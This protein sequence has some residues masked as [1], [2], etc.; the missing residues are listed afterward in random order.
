MKLMKTKLT[1]TA[2]L[3]ILPLMFIGLVACGTDD[4]VASKAGDV[5]GDAGNVAIVDESQTDEDSLTAGVVDEHDDAD[6]HADAV[7]DSHDSDPI[8]K[9]EHEEEVT[10]GHGHADIATPVDP[11]APVMHVLASEFIYDTTT[12]EV[13]AGE[14]FSIQIHNEG[15]LE[16]DI[17]FVGLESEFGLHVQPGEDDIATFSIDEPGEY[18][19]YCTVLGHREAGMTGTLVVTGAVVADHE[20]A[21]HDD[22]IEVVLEDDSH[23]DDDEA[24]EE[25]LHDEHGEHDA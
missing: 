13:E 18:V 22:A 7:A 3:L 9:T 4:G 11:D 16:H 24:H 8:V 1:T 25:E 15:S 19:Y 21:G 20:E 23:L 10:E 6:E 2:I 14:T 17:T 12:T 5:I